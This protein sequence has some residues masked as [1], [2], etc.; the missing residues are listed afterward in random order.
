MKI[1]D[2]WY[3]L[4]HCLKFIHSTTLLKKGPLL[5]YSFK[6]LALDYEV[7]FL[8][9]YQWL[10]LEISPR[11]SL[12]VQVPPRGFAILDI[13]SHYSITVADRKTKQYIYV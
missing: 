3:G 13:S 1:C 6:T 7:W 8:E 11:F 10:N 12:R 4:S 9:F 2:C 5:I